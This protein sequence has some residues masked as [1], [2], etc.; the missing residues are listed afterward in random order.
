MPQK[1]A[2]AIYITDFGDHF[3][4][5]LGSFSGHFLESIFEKFLDNF[6]VPFGVRLGSQISPGHAR[7]APGEPSRAAKQ[8]KGD[9][10]NNMF[11]QVF[12]VQRLTKRALGS[13]KRLIYNKRLKSSKTSKQ[14]CKKINDLC[15]TF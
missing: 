5:I 14:I 1:L 10:K 8:R 13:P 2:K 6:W 11:F 7:M 4:V 15:N 12:G 9:L 3:E